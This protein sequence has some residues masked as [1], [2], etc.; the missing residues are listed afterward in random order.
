MPWKPS[1][2]GEVPTLGYGVI[3]WIEENLAHPAFVDVRRWK[4]YR[5]VEDFILGF[6]VLDPRAPNPWYPRVRGRRRI[7]RALLGRPRGFSK[8]PVLAAL[9]IAE[10]LGPVV[11]AG[12]D[13]AG[14]PVGAPWS[15]IV[16]FLGQVTAVSE[17][18][19]KNTWRPLLRMLDGPVIDNYPELEP[20]GTFVNL[21][22][23][24]VIENRTSAG[25]SI[26]GAPSQFVVLDQTEEWTASNGGVDLADTI[27][28]NV[29]KV[30]GSS[31]ESP[32]AFIPGDGS[33]AEQSAAFAQSIAE[34]RSLNDGL[35][36]DHREAPPDT[37]MYER[38]SVTL[39][40]RHAYG[41]ASGHPGGCVIHEPPCPP[42]H[43]DLES[44]IQRI[45]DPD[46]DPQKARANF[47]N[48]ITHAGDSWMDRVT[49]S[50][51][52]AF[53]DGMDP[54]VPPVADR[55]VV[56]LGFDG[57]RGRAKGKPDA[58]ALIGCRV[59]DGHLF[60]IEV[61]E[62]PDSPEGRD[63][64]PPIPVIEAAIAR[65]FE[66]FRVAAF[67]ADPAKDWR[68]YVNS[69]E[70]RYAAKL[71]P[72]PNGRQVTSTRDHPFEWWMT[73]GRTGLIQRAIEQL[74]GAIRNGDM[75]HDGGYALTR[76]VLNARRR[77]RRNKLALAKENDY[78]SKKIDA[79]VAAVLAWQARLDAV[80]AGI[81][82]TEEFVAP[83]RLR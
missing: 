6:Y 46:Y 38:E 14:Q 35:L 13:A 48:Q 77:I 40:L 83:R 28:D 2:P 54:E 30:G 25:A 45:W 64:R 19:T 66:R 79:A 60:E 37:E 43:V 47:L 8:S 42:G 78:S 34:G 10:S 65:T 21:P 57:S 23:N 17:D 59:H 75:T 68:S 56:T 51:R 74:E 50:S 15:S 27:R 58:T 22:G 41:D 18:Q 12:W 55:D 36:Y 3:D 29:A 31:I 16:P 61:W 9:M 1:E 80:A 24:G 44:L 5:E 70:A 72:A 39:G 82:Q 71:H 20:L 81:K 63:W 7:Q 26:K 73:G 32:N 69:W 11:P 62:A 52:Y 4:L 33:V 53:R 67:Y 49:W 76:H